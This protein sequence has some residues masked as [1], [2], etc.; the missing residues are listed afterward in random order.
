MSEM[1]GQVERRVNAGTKPT[2]RVPG[3]AASYGDTAVLGTSPGRD[4]N[5]SVHVEL[6]WD[7]ATEPDMNVPEKSLRRDLIWACTSIPTT[8]SQPGQRLSRITPRVWIG[9]RRQS[10]CS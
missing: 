8:T 4:V 5:D 6:A 3:N 1:R 10:W 7:M 2:G 9:R